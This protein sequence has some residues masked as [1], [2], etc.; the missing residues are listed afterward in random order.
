M[1]PAVKFSQ[2]TQIDSHVPAGVNKLPR[3]NGYIS[4]THTNRGVLYLFLKSD[5]CAYT[6]HTSSCKSCAVPPE[7]ALRVSNDRRMPA[8]SMQQSQD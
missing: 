1:R 8:Q 5:G 3:L 4:N 7:K 2:E 6:K